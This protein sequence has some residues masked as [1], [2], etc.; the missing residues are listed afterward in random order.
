[1]ITIVDVARAGDA[2]QVRWRITSETTVRLTHAAA[3]HGNFRAADAT[4]DL[5]TP[6][7]LVLEVVSSAP[8]LNDIENAFLILTA[9]DGARAWRILA[10]M[11]VRLDSAGVPHPTIERVDVQEVGFSGQ[12]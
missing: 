3:P 9:E 4:L 11:R 10:R 5:E 12:R 1:M 7:D 6:T 8:P 2:W